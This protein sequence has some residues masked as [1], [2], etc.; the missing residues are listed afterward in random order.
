[1][2]NLNVDFADRADMTIETVSGGQRAAR[3][4]VYDVNGNRIAL[5]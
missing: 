3:G 1:V 2:R 4:V 5:Y